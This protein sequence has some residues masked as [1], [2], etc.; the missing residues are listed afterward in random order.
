MD[1]RNA[2]PSPT[3]RSDA[4]ERRAAA[5][6]RSFVVR[7]GRMGPG[8]ARA[9]AMLSSRYVVPFTDATIDFE[10]LFGRV[11]PV[12]AEIGF[13]MGAATATIAAARP[14]V[15]FLGIEVHPP[16]VGALLQRID[17]A[18]NRAT[19]ASSS[20]TRSRSWSR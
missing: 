11:A 6:I 13:G 19:C 12:V 5:R 2:D 7:A 3:A 4:R 17:E 9:L 14:D 20:T 18:Q 1:E 10:A 8:Q 15:D 16:G